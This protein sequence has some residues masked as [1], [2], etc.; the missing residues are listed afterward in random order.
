MLN[1]TS[2]GRV[3]FLEQ[4]DYIVFPKNM[5]KHFFITSLTVLFRVVTTVCL[6]L[7]SWM[8]I[9]G[10]EIIIIIIRYYVLDSEK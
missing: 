3:Q 8:G 1:M 9:K 4:F 10:R 7:V 2:S 6:L 5:R